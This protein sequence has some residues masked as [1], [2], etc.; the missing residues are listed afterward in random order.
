[1]I[2]PLVPFAIRG[3]IWYQGEGNSS[4]AYQYRALLPAM[5]KNWRD[6]WGQGQF[7]FLIVQ[8]APYMKIQAEPMESAWAEL[9]EAQTMTAFKHP[10]CGLAVI[11]DAGEEDDIHPRLKQPAG[12]RLALAARAIAYGE[13]IE[14]SG[15]LYKSMKVAGNKAILTFDH[16]GGG[17]VAKD[18]ALKGF[19]IAGEDRQFHNAEAVIEGTTVV[20]SSSRVAKPAA[21]R[22]GWANFPVVNLWNK[23]GLPAPPFRTDDWPGITHPDRLAASARTPT[24]RNP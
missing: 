3:A 22:Y 21:V 17:L 13:T 10:N 2:G 18:G 1:M 24:R 11:T 9:R 14:F 19:T 5:I 12:A 15:P 8:L 4:R 6:D 7:P 23:A 16:L 20:V